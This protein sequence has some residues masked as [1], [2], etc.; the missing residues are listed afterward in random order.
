M[1]LAYI[2]L[3]ANLGDP[4]ATFTAALEKLGSMPGIRVMRRSSFYKSPPL[5]PP[6]PDYVNAVA[7]VETSRSPRK[8]MEALLSVET[9]YGRIRG[10]HKWQPRLL[11]LD[12]LFYGADV[13]D[14]P[15][16]HVPHPELHKRAFVLVPLAEITPELRHPALGLTTRELCL[17]LPQEDRAGVRLLEGSA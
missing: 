12:L 8:L 16:L 2:G 4:P 17:S 15:F 9:R 7:E 14:E 5:G 10:M 1:T 13:I 11:D 3:G 6:Q